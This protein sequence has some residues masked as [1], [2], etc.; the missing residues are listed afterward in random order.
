MMEK[1]WKRLVEMVAIM[2]IYLMLLNCMLPKTEFG[3][4][5]RGLDP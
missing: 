1:F 5:F 4:K 2:R 3:S